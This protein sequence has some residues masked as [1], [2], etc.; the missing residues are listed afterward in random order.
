MQVSTFVDRGMRAPNGT[1]SQNCHIGPHGTNFSAFPDQKEGYEEGRK[2]NQ[3][4]QEQIMG[5]GML[6]VAEL[7]RSK[8]WDAQVPRRLLFE[9]PSIA[10][11][12]RGFPTRR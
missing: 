6:S 1:N 4:S 3:W 9:A 8:R 2:R 7:T 11:Q 5:E 10:G 12:R